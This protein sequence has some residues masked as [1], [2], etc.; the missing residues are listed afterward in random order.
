[1]IRSFLQVS[2]RLVKHTKV[3]PTVNFTASTV[4]SKG[5]A[6]GCPVYG[7]AKISKKD[8]DKQKLD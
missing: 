7:F 4:H 2:V 3:L 5:L 1:M 6:Q 8:K